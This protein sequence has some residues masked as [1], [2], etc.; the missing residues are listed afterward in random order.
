MKTREKK[1]ND[2]IR[3]A[4]TNPDI[5]AV[6]LTSSLANPYA[7]VDDLSDLDIELILTDRN[8]YETE[9]GWIRVFGEPV[10]IIEESAEAFDG[11]H[12]MKIVLYSDHVKVDFKLYGTREFNQEVQSEAF[13]E[14]WDVGYNVLVDKD[15]ITGSMKAPSY[16]SIMIAKPSEEEFYRLIK[17]FWWD[18]AYVAKCLN[19]GDIFYVKYMAENI[20]R[21][22]Y[23]IPLI[24]WHI[25]SG[26]HWKN[27]TTNKHGRLFKKYL[28][29]GL[30]Q[31]VEATF[32][33]HDTEENWNA[34]WAMTD[35]VHTLGI[36][37]S[38]HL[39]YTYPL[40]IEKGM[41]KHLHYVQNLKSSF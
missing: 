29:N 12:A 30:W 32:S 31:K 16:Q 8:R 10:C 20:I 6:L 9:D 18:T 17:D 34:L 38:E 35:L 2:I 41:M 4:E 19:R 24:E 3:W 37:L 39:G 14:D 7:P 26:H 11:I 28:S 15:G 36:S 1:L 22:E 23:L 27:I 25:A 33:G 5:R 40:E 21:T 13:P